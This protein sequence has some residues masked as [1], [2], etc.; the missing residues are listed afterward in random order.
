MKAEEAKKFIEANNK[1]VEAMFELFSPEAKEL[2][3]LSIISD[4]N[5]RI[6]QA[7][8][9]LTDKLEVHDEGN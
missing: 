1:T 3:L 2:L 6:L 5:L 4:T 7:V 9:E 8:A